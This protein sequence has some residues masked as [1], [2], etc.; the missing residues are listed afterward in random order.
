MDGSVLSML[1]LMRAVQSG[2]SRAECYRPLYRPSVCSYMVLQETDRVV[3][4]KK[5]ITQIFCGPQGRR[6]T[7][8][9]LMEPFLPRAADNIC[10]VPYKA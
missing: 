9:G 10:L 1:S 3:L 6:I 7:Y 2:V 4:E 8:W 5:I